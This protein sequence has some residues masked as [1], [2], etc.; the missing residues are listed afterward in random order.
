V[1]KRHALLAAFENRRP[2]SE[3]TSSGDGD[4]HK[5]LT[6]TSKGAKPAGRQA[7]GGQTFRG[8][9][10]C[11]DGVPSARARERARECAPRTIT[12]DV[13]V[14]TLNP[15]CG[16]EAKVAC[17]GQPPWADVGTLGSHTPTYMFP[18]HVSGKS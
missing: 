9:G 13:L 16:L 7:A 1:H 18:V 17:L 11:T 12:N 3:N 14:G 5:K 4:G 15:N 2:H 10:V 6:R 8:E